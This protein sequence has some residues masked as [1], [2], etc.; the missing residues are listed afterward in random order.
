MYSIC[1]YVFAHIL[2]VYI[3][4]CN[5]HVKLCVYMYVYVCAYIHIC[6]AFSGS[7]CKCEVLGFLCS[8][9]LA[10]GLVRGS[11]SVRRASPHLCASFRGLGEKDTVG[12]C[13]RL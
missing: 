8:L 6:I 1:L 13:R 7:L 4:I 5:V 3:Y 10:L 11:H 2:Y 9:R 12:V